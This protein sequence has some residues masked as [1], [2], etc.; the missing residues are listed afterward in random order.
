M[1]EILKTCEKAARL[2]GS[3]LL[4]MQKSIKPREKA[5]RDLVTEA[6]LASQKASHA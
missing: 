2:G 4:E 3:I 1:L 6:D 5:P